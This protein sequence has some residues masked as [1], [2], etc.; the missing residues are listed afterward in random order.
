MNHICTVCNHLRSYPGGYS[1]CSKYGCQLC[2]LQPCE[3]CL[4]EGGCDR[5]DVESDG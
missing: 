2:D 3:Q 5:W 4:R 1:E